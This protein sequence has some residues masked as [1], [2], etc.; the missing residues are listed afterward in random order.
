MGKARGGLARWSNRSCASLNRS[1][2]GYFET[3]A[4]PVP[5]DVVSAN[6]TVKVDEVK[7]YGLG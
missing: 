4:P 3:A 7:V 5:S 1:S 6:S 2:P